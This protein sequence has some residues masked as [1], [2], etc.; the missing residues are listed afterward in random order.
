[1]LEFYLKNALSD[2]HNFELQWSE[3]SA[4]ENIGFSEIHPNTLAVFSNYLFFDN[5]QKNENERDLEI[6]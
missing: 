5:L 6:D 1:M 4:K 3:E 2:N